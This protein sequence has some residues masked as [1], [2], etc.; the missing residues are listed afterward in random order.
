MANKYYDRFDVNSPYFKAG[1]ILWGLYMIY[2][3]NGRK[4]KPTT[5]KELTD[6]LNKDFKHDSLGIH[7]T[8]EEMETIMKDLCHAPFIIQEI[9]EDGTTGYWAGGDDI[10]RITRYCKPS[11]ED[12]VNDSKFNNILS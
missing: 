8:Y 4:P 11:L 6:I 10:N 5:T 2:V 3:G 9:R 12:K 7:I 1:H